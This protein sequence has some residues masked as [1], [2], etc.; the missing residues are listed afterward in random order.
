MAEQA[1]AFCIAPS[2]VGSA[3]ASSDGGR[4]DKTLKSCFL[5]CELPMNLDAGEALSRPFFFFLRCGDGVVAFSGGSRLGGGAAAAAGDEEEEAASGVTEEEEERE[6]EK[7]EEEEA[8][9]AAAGD[10]GEREEE[11]E[12][13]A[14]AAAAGEEEEARRRNVANSSVRTTLSTHSMSRSPGLV[15]KP[16]S[17]V[18]TSCV[19]RCCDMAAQL[20]D[21]T[22][23]ACFLHGA[24]M[25][26]VSY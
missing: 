17:V 4:L 11:K 6:E 22:G 3:A 2:P 19:N 20:G 25:K 15:N 9:P 5:A 24:K 14:A 10:G 12:G 7:E 23:G 18:R 21:A 8:P 16:N 1:S 13:A 26:G